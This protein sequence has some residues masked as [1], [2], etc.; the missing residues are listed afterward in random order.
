MTTAAST[1][2]RTVGIAVQT[3]LTNQPTTFDEIRTHEAITFP[4]EESLS[5]VQPNLGHE[6]ALNW[7]DKPI[8]FEGVR[9]NGMTIPVAFRRGVTTGKPPIAKFAES[10]GCAVNTI[11]D[12]TISTYVDEGSF[13]LT[14]PPAST[15]YGAA[16]LVELNDGSYYPSLTKV[17]A[18][19]GSTT[20][21][22][23]LP[24]ASATSKNV[25]LM[26]TI[27]PQTGA[28]DASKLLAVKVNTRG[29]HTT[30]EDLAWIMYGCSLGSF[31]DLVIEPQGQF[32]MSPTFHVADVE[33]SADPISAES[34][35]DTTYL[36]RNQGGFT[37][38]FAD[39][40]SAG[41]ITH[42]NA[43]LLKATITPGHTSMP[44]PGDGCDESLNSTQ[45][46][47][48]STPEQPKVVLELLMDKAYWD[49]FS[50]TG[51]TSKHIGFVW[52]TT[53]LAIPAYGFW[54]P[55]C[56]QIASPVGDVISEEYMK[57]TVTY[58]ATG[59]GYGGGT[60][61]NSSGNSPWF[62]AIHGESV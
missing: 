36:Q 39:A 48:A 45:G 27:T 40:S 9:E 58:G 30:S 28:V 37:F 34:F 12:T 41:G 56:H 20:P 29:T 1:K 26:H 11:A 31:G 19:D 43:C 44:I 3:S 38:E 25:K 59:A 60:S 13:S 8:T 5:E 22:M 57:V 32:V 62:M 24:S 53:N 51:N 16:I 6:N 52:P 17:I 4:T 46:Y 18:D 55:N 61:N 7:D 2:G 42:T 14:L 47:I 10:G 35:I 50:T 54:M 23:D 49:T 33:Q 21:G 15:T